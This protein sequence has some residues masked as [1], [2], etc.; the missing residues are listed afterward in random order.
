VN[1]YKKRH[2]NKLCLMVVLIVAL[3]LL[4]SACGDDSATVIPGAITVPDEYETIQE[5]I[6]TAEDGDVIA[7][8]PGT[9]KEG[10]NFRGKNITLRSMDPD[11]PD[12]VAETVIDGSAANSVVVFA[13][14]ESA[15][16]VLTG[17]TITG[18]SGTTGALEFEVEGEVTEVPSI[19]GGGILI[20]ENSSPTITK[21]HIT[22]NIAERG[23]GIMVHG[24][25]PE[26]SNNMIT[27][28]TSVGGGAGLFIY[29]SAI[30]LIDNV[31]SSNSAGRSGGGIT[32]MGEADTPATLEGNTISDNLAVSF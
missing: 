31:I 1:S 32:I 2:S 21:N 5:A 22:N 12:I 23:A 26:I 17:F 16:A 11:D 20:I 18:G 3:S 15:Q 4:V 9:Y 19:Y 27:D 28:N 6:E 30:N 10:I 24:S 14:G 8:R 25:S 29:D 7:V 13:N